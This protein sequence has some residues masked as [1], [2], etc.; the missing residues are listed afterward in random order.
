MQ[1]DVP[2]WRC[3]PIQRIEDL[4]D[5]VRGAG[6]EA[7]Q[8]TR[9]GVCG[10]LA[11]A[12][13]DGIIT[14]SGL[15]GGRVSLTGPLSADKVTFG[16]GLRVAQGTRHWM[17]EVE[18]GDIGVFLPGDEHDSVYTAGTL[19][20]TVTLTLERL[21]AEA[22]RVGVVLDP[23]T[24]GGTGFHARR[25]RPARM[26]LLRDRMYAVHAGHIAPG[27]GQSLG[28]HL[29]A[30]SINHYARDP[31]PI[32]GAS[33]AQGHARVVERARAYISAHLKEP[34][35]LASLANAAA[36]SERTLHRAFQSLL[37]ESPHSYI[38]RLRSHRIRHD[39]ATETEMACSVAIVANRWGIGELGRLAGWYRELFGELPS[40]TLA[41]R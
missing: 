35:S 11:F 9:E 13:A 21:E 24:L 12:E 3:I 30:V 34:I 5:A 10:S 8:M 1:S 26:A 6:L 19:Y 17:R 22:A 18:T 23:G 38:R 14:S 16:I 39:L 32:A 40:E 4:S 7:T 36:A 31:R 20:A 37:E 25:L 28:R 41:R 15:I 33:R 27:L 29:L 2:E